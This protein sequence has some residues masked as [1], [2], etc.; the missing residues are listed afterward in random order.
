M[1]NF[2]NIATYKFAL[3]SDLKSL[4]E[5]LKLQCKHWGVKGTIL[6]STEGI[7][8]FVAGRSAEIEKLLERL[9][10]IPHLGP[11]N[12]KISESRHQP[13]QRM[14][15][16]IKKEIIAFGVE[17]INPAAYT[18][19]K[20]SPRELKE[21]LDQGRA[22]TLLDTRNDYEIKLG[23]FVNAQSLGL[24]HFRDFPQAAMNLPPTLKKTPVVMFCTGGIRCEKAGPF[25]ET[26]GFENILQL[27]GGILKYFEDC[28]NAHYRGDCF[29][30][31]KR[32]GVDPTLRETT[33]AQCFACLTPLTETEQTDVRYEKGQSCPYCFKTD[34]QKMKSVIAA[35]HQKISEVMNPLPGSVPYHH[36]RPL[37]VPEKFHGVSVFQ[38]V[39]GILNHVG[40]S[41]WRE[42]FRQQF[43]L[44]PDHLPTGETATVRSGERY[45]HLT[46]NLREPAVNTDVKILY[47]DEAVIVL[48]KP[49]PLPI[50]AGGRYN[51]NTLQFLL[52]QVYA[53]LK[54]FPAHRLDAN[55]TGLLLV[56]KTR[57]FS[58]LLQPQF[59]RG[60]VLK[61]YL[62]RVNGWPA[63]DQFSCEL[64]LG[65]ETQAV[66]ARRAEISGLPSKT[67]FRVLARFNDDTSLLEVQPLTGRTNQIR[68]HLWELGFP[69]CGEQL[70]LPQKKLG[71]TQ[72]GHI[73]DAPLCLHAQRL[74][75]IHPLTQRRVTFESQSSARPS[76][77]KKS[78][79]SL[80][81]IRHYQN[82]PD[83]F[84]VI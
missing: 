10:S 71:N 62:A 33:D 54:P 23:T 36:E 46:P 37:R 77:I 66:G 49:A 3:L 82:S 6:L 68:I 60:E 29:V 1:E 81:N 48:E 16:R 14:L 18:S 19:N 17:G 27:D 79:H 61:T 73:G 20:I 52:E 38:F 25:L 69:I 21:W 57:H 42:E 24:R 9:Q 51:R 78:A 39:S 45:Y 75:F 74:S 43:I 64:A 22:F 63:E 55:T 50:H 28:G 5:S 40:E 83:E 80:E 34:E 53:P 58:R 65:E 26:Q 15:V 35:R 30:F 12:P 70:Y 7:N 84:G 2:T 13:F 59:S 44:G 67:E 31:D 4:R 56:A 47:E 41:Q 72:T 11:L 76:W 8:L 32:V